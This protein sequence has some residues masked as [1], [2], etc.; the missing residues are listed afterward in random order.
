LAAR[1]AEVEAG[2]EAKKEAQRLA[3]QGKEAHA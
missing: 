2:I 3:D 1:R